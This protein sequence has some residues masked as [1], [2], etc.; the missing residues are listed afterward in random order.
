MPRPIHKFDQAF[1]GHS[2][3]PRELFAPAYALLHSD[4]ENMNFVLPKRAYQVVSPYTEQLEDE[5]GGQDLMTGWTSQQ[6]YGQED[7]DAKRSV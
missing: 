1:G 4:M 5:L 6:G 2:H 3:P 7:G